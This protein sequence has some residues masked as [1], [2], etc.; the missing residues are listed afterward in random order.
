[1]IHFFE[2]VGD[3]YVGVSVHAL[4]RGYLLHSICTEALDKYDRPYTNIDTKNK[5]KKHWKTTTRKTQQK[6]WE[7]NKTKEE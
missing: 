2:W 6:R 5:K 1:M 7:G 4:S 3:V